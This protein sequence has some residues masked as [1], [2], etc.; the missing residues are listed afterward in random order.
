MSLINKGL[1]LVITGILKLLMS[2]CGILALYLTVCKTT[3]NEGYHPKQWVISASDNC[4][5]VYVYHQFILVFLYF[6]TPLV[7][8]CH[9]LLVPW[10]GLVV[11][12][13]FSLLLTKLTLKTKIGRFLIG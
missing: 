1:I 4:Y 12:F 2:C 11:I 13:S 9:P 7:A 3:T 5:G 10:I 8:V 6:Y